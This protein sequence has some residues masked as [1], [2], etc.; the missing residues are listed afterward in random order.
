M[1]FIDRLSGQ[2]VDQPPE[3]AHF[4]R[5]R[6]GPGDGPGHSNAHPAGDG[7]VL[8]PGATGDWA[9]ARPGDTTPIRGRFFAGAIPDDQD[10]EALL[11][12]GQ[13]LRNP[14]KA[15]GGWLEWSGISPLAPGLDEAVKP[16][17]LEDR[18]QAEVEH[19]AAVC[20]SPRTHIR[21]ETERVPRGPRPPDCPRRAGAARV[22]HGRLGT[23]HYRRNP[24]TPNTRPGPGR[25]MG[26][27]REPG[28]GA[29]RR[30]SRLV[31]APADC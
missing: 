18:I 10:A 16:H 25:T 19:L 23:S 14:D 26:P 22:P 24:A 5:W 8:V 20:R 15:K 12:L 3:R 21:R 13:V 29:P 6:F 17:P 2:S 28:G 11:Q 7:D 30:R 9:L 4:G 1:S 31:A 27:L